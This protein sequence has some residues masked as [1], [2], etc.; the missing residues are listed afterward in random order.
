MTI[1]LCDNHSIISIS[2]LLSIKCTD[3]NASVIRMQCIL[4]YASLNFEQKLRSVSCVDRFESDAEVT[5][6]V[7]CKIESL[8]ANE[9]EEKK[10]IEGY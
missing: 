7:L 9:Q 4:T 6:F 1:I 8:L 3:Y 2:L 10:F 5:D